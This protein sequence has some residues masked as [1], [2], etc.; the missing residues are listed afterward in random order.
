MDTN[1]TNY[2]AVV[3]IPGQGVDLPPV[4]LPIDMDRTGYYVTD[5]SV[6]HPPGGT[7][8]RCGAGIVHRA[9]NGEFWHVTIIF[10]CV[11]SSFLTEVVAIAAAI[12]HSELNPC[13]ILSDCQSAL[14]TIYILS[15]NGTHRMMYHTTR[16][17]AQCGSG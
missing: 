9:S 11:V 16:T 7:T 15:I 13:P 14:Y 4:H 10:R 3:R 12:L 1:T 17:V 6:T 8:A 2:C 5:G